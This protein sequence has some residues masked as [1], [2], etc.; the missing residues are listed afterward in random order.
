M[1]PASLWPASTVCCVASGA[2]NYFFYLQRQVP[3]CALKSQATTVAIIGDVSKVDLSFGV[4]M[5]GGVSTL[6]STRQNLTVFARCAE[7]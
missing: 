3:G 6:A 1:L 5:H 7:V 4:S 2:G